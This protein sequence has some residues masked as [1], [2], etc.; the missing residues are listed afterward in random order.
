MSYIHLQAVTATETTHDVFLNVFN[1]KYVEVSHKRQVGNT[2]IHMVGSG[3]LVPVATPFKEVAG[4]FPTL[5]RENLPNTS[6]EPDY[7]GSIVYI[8]PQHVNA[9]LPI[10]DMFLLKFSDG[11]ELTVRS[12]PAFLASIHKPEEH[13][14]AS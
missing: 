1:I 3:D 5:T 7:E 2:L 4:L 11:S 10:K 8:N 13:A 9:V 12:R 14:I 6:S